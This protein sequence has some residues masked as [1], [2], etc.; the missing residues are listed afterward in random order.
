[1]GEGQRNGKSKEDKGEEYKGEMAEK[2]CKDKS[3]RVGGRE[4][5]QR[6]EEKREGDNG[7]GE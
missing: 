3:T 2:G 4:R 1:M 5:V 7:R 6:K